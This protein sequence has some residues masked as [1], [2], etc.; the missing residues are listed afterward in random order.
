MFYHTINNYF[1]LI[2]ML[3]EHLHICF[4]HIYITTKSLFLSLQFEVLYLCHPIQ[5]FAPIVL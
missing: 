5:E 2:Y 4:S 1:V 3:N